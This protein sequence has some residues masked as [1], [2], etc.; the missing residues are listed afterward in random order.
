MP[1]T[2]ENVQQ[3]LNILETPFCKSMSLLLTAQRHK[4]QDVLLVFILGIQTSIRVETREVMKNS[5]GLGILLVFK[6]NGHGSES[7]LLRGW[8]KAFVLTKPG[9][10]NIKTT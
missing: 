5:Q 1:L 9:Q 10:E 2:A 4:I 8:I 7:V 6:K 3:E